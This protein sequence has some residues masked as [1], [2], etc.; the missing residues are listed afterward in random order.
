[1]SSNIETFRCNSGDV[2]G[3][4]VRVP[5][6]CSLISLNRQ[7]GGMGHTRFVYC[8]ADIAPSVK[9][10]DLELNTLQEMIENS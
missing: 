4:Y 6:L 10:K 2:S 9:I 8:Y 1:M 7:G 3:Y 5:G